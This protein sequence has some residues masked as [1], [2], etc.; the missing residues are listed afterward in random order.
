MIESLKTTILK[1]PSLSLFFRLLAGVTLVLA[2][3]TKLPYHSHFVEIVKGYHL[4]PDPLATAYALALPWFELVAGAYLILG[5]LLQPAAVVTLLIG[6]S[7]LVANVSAILRGEHYCGSCFGE[8]FPLLLSQAMF[9]DALIIIAA[10]VL[11]VG[12]RKEMLSFD[13]WF[14][15]RYCGTKTA[16]SEAT[17]G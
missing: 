7:F 4:L 9:L 11:L 6:I 8:A 15:R 14:Q 2:S 5:I 17:R 10:L 12:G 3:I 1:S 16:G 13:S